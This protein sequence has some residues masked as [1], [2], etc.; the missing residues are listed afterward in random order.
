MDLSHDVLGL[1]RYFSRPIT[2]SDWR[3]VRLHVSLSY[4]CLYS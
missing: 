4:P 1:V 3:T 2:P